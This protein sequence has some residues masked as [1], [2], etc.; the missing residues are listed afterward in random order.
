MK[1]QMS[2]TIL[3]ETIFKMSI[4]LNQS[5]GENIFRLRLQE[6]SG[7]ELKI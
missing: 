6:I 3:R 7:N 4:H 1:K 2:D 5:K